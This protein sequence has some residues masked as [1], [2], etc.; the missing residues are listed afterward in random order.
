MSVRDVSF[1]HVIA[2]L[3]GKIAAKE[4]SVIPLFEDEDT[5]NCFKR[6]LFSFLT[7]LF[8]ITLLLRCSMS[9][10]F[11]NIISVSINYVFLNSI[12][13]SWSMILL[14]CVFLCLC[15]MTTTKSDTRKEDRQSEK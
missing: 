9:L 2:H 7:S 3:E 4:S 13:I 15:G 12:T 10:S 14:L 1:V 5:G 6:S 8:L 11:L